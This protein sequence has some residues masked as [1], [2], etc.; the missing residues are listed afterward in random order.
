MKQRTCSTLSQGLWGT[1]SFVWMYVLF[2][3]AITTCLCMIYE[4]TL[5]ALPVYSNVFPFLTLFV[6]SLNLTF[7][8]I[9]VITTH[10]FW[11]TRYL[12]YQPLACLTVDSSRVH[13]GG[14]LRY[15]LHCLKAPEK[16]PRTKKMFGRIDHTHLPHFNAFTNGT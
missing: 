5:V 10:G 12:F 1:M 15:Y 4:Y 11:F 2:N 7:C 8:P 13:S 9:A 16:E 14:Y 3:S 6:I